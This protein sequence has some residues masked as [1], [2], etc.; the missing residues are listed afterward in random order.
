MANSFESKIFNKIPIDDEF[1]DKYKNIFIKKKD[2]E[3][4]GSVL[5]NTET[6][7]R[8]FSNI[9]LKIFSLIIF[10]VLFFYGSIMIL[11]AILYLILFP[12]TG[13]NGLL[14]FIDFTKI[15]SKLI[16][17]SIISGFISLLGIFF[18][19]IFNKRL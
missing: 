17:T 3:A 8:I 6:R 12:L 11:Y 5:K 2:A 15:D 9:F 10:L 14:F 19:S 18:N 4:T 7:V 1:V 13:K 16:F